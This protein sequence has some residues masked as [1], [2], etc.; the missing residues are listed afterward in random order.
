MRVA[1]ASAISTQT[2]SRLPGASGPAIEPVVQLLV[3]PGTSGAHRLQALSNCR[4]TRSIMVSMASNSAS[5]IGVNYILAKD[6]DNATR[7]RSSP[8]SEL[9]K[10][11]SICNRY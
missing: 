4:E 6:L 5:V 8:L 9:V 7:R 11:L 2:K 1:M 10:G 3:G